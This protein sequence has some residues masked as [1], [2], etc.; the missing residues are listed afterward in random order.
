[1][2]IYCIT[3]RIHL[4]L[5]TFFTVLPFYNLF[6]PVGPS[7]LSRHSEQVLLGVEVSSISNLEHP[8]RHVEN[9][10]ITTKG[11]HERKNTT[12]DWDDGE[13]GNKE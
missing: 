2:G 7:S 6:F 9:V 1:M 5:I 12:I 11:L 10:V 8:T 13:I 4:F 3:I